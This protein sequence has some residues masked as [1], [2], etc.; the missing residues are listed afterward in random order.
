VIDA[1]G[2]DMTDLFPERT[3]DD[4]TQAQRKGP[5]RVKFYASDLLRVIHFEATVVMVAAHDVAKG[6]RL[7]PPD[8]ERVQQAY[9]RIDSAMKAAD[10]NP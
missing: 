5:E 9:Q 1:L 6:R 2:M 4:Y 8:M 7:S 3:R 10:G